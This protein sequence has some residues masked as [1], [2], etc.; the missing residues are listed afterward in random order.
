MT[1]IKCR[2]CGK[3]VSDK[4]T[5]CPNCGYPFPPKETYV[6]SKAGKRQKNV[7]IVVI[8]GILI[9][10][11]VLFFVFM[12][13]NN[14]DKKS[15]DQLLNRSSLESVKEFLG[16]DYKEK[17]GFIVYENVKIDGIVFDEISCNK[18]KIL[19]QCDNKFETKLIKLLDKKFEKNEK[20]WTTNTGDEIYLSYLIDF[21]GLTKFFK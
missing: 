19:L 10:C 7:A 3:E 9:L 1:L 17:D 20:H 18:T 6:P 14:S 2:E 12:I 15:L 21:I 13:L 5:V 4:A 8:I 16:N 11:S